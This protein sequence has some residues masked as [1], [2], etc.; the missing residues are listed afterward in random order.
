ML[1]HAQSGHQH[2]ADALDDKRLERVQQ[3]GS[4]R[5]LVV[6]AA[7]ALLPAALAMAVALTPKAPLPPPP[8]KPVVVVAEAP[9]PAPPPDPTL[10]DALGKGEALGTALARHG[11]GADD[12]S[13]LVRDLKG[14]L[15]VRSLRAGAVYSVLVDDARRLERFTFKTTNGEGVPRLVTASRLAVVDEAVEAPA[16]GGSRLPVERAARF[17]VTIDDARVEID[18]EGLAGSVRGSL[19]N[20][21]LDAGGD[22]LLVNKFVDVFAWNIDFYRQAQ[23]GDSFRVL[24]EKRFANDGN[25]RRFLGW[26]DVVAAEYVNAGNAFRGFAFETSDKKFAGFYDDKGESLERTF[27]RSPMEVTRITSS[28]GS[29]FHPVLKAQKKHEGVDYGA[30]VG[31]PVWSVADGIVVDA[32]FSKSA[33]NMVVVQ[34][35]NGLRTEYFHLS[36][37]AEGVR[38]GS[39]VTQKQ[40]IGYVGSTGMSTGPHL[41]FGL[42]RGNSH[43]DPGTQKSENARPMPSSYRP[44]FD[45]FVA[46]LMAQLAALTRA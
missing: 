1:R 46:P 29:R 16:R 12:V 37:F 45:A 34:H 23:S 36:K 20:G 32:R 41:H 26:G 5:R 3:P 28:Y 8:P 13:N 25:E 42:L 4:R 22:A 11:I 6:V 19:Y 35:V 31:T 33:G 7:A 14:V 38:A 2:R 39:R 9:P 30:P 24:V 17:S 27:L 40:A 44:E 15:E 18:I 43:L 21:V 10:H